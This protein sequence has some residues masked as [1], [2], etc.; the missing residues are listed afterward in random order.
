MWPQTK[1]S[2]ALEVSHGSKYV[3]LW[4]RTEQLFT[5]EVSHKAILYHVASHTALLYYCRLKQNYWQGG[6]EGLCVFRRA[7]RKPPR[8]S[9]RGSESNYLLLWPHTKQFVTIWFAIRQ[10]TQC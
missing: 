5:I 2:F 6:S 3:L 4:S 7:G 8:V 10:A 1:Q 9:K